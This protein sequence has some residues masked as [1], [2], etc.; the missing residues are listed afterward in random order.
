M[1]G[2]RIVKKLVIVINGAGG[3]GK[4]ALCAAASA[5]FAVKNVSAITPIKKIALENGWDGQKT[6]RARKFL[7]DLKRCFIAFNDLPNR[8]LLSEYRD[9]LR[10][11][12]EI[13]FVH[14][15]EGDQIDAFKREVS[16]IPCV[17]LLVRRAGQEYGVGAERND[18]DDNVERYEYDYRYDNDKS[19]TD[20][21]RDFPVFLE[22]I[23][24]AAVRKGSGE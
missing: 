19:L 24:H 13:L 15:R 14:I 23:F 10:D 22:N 9:F 6:P 8:Y 16:E 12:N 3:V 20:A 11:G 4:D 21:E 17:T 7:S 18:S 5:R 1:G 2:R